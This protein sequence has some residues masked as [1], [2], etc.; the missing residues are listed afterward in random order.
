MQLKLKR[1]K[2]NQRVIEIAIGIFSV[3]RGRAAQTK[4]ENKE[5]KPRE[6]KTV[7]I[8]SLASLM[9][10]VYIEF[11]SNV[12]Q[13]S[14]NVADPRTPTLAISCYVE[15]PSKNVVQHGFLRSYCVFGEQ[16]PSA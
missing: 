12:V 13:H 6:I 14:G 9:E 10:R 11:P 7:K 5:R 8:R 4:K 2:R 1:N 16:F 15:L 3:R